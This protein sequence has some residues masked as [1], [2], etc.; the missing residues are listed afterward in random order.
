MA[1]FLGTH[2]PRLDDKGRVFLPAKY[3]EDLADGLVVTR[4]QEH[5]LYVFTKARF[6]ELARALSSA[7][8]TSAPARDLHRLF[9][10]GAFDEVPDKTGRVGGLPL[11]QGGRVLRTVLGGG[12]ARTLTQPA[13]S[14][15]RSWRSVSPRSAPD[16]PSPVPGATQVSGR[17]PASTIPSTSPHPPTSSARE[18]EGSR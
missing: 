13:K 9:F 18:P 4:G 3:R 1:L 14:S 16:S 8:F 7:S 12:G 2:A 17:G 10:S 6:E 15:D 5:C 11:H